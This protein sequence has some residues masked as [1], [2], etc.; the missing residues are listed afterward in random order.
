MKNNNKRVKKSNHLFYAQNMTNIPCHNQRQK[1]GGCGLDTNE[2]EVRV[3][4]ERQQNW[5]ASRRV[6]L[7]L[8]MAVASK[9][10]R[11]CIN[12]F[13]IYDWRPVTRSK[14]KMR[15]TLIRHQ[16]RCPTSIGRAATKLAFFKR[17]SL[18]TPDGG[19]VKS[20]LSRFWVLREI[21]EMTRLTGS[22]DRVP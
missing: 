4:D 12:N 15:T 16:W 1:R 18:D 6:L 11:S 14:P 5:L 21:R 22:P 10:D 17:D 2:G 7:T 13:W 9:P 19:S 8:Q 3:S 20:S